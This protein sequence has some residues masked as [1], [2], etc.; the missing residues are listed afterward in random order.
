MERSVTSRSFLQ[1]FRAGEARPTQTDGT[2]SLRPADTPSMM[3]VLAGRV[4]CLEA[5]LV[6]LGFDPPK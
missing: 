6:A 1:I 4:D 3:V 5:G 2:E